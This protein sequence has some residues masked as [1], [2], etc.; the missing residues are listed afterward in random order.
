MSKNSIKPEP[1][2][3]G[4]FVNF[5]T[6]K[7]TT[8]IPVATAVEQP[9]MVDEIGKFLQA[10]L[11][12]T[13]QDIERQLTPR[14]A[15]SERTQMV[16]AKVLEAMTGVQA[17]EIDFWATN[18]LDEQNGEARRREIQCPSLLPVTS[19]PVPDEVLD[20]KRSPIDKILQKERAPAPY[21]FRIGEGMLAHLCEQQEYNLAIDILSQMI[22]N[23]RVAERTHFSRVR[24]ENGTNANYFNLAANSVN[25]HLNSEIGSHM[26][27]EQVIARSDTAN[28]DA[29]GIT[30]LLFGIQK[31]GK[32]RVKTKRFR[33][34][35]SSAIWKQVM[36]PM[37]NQIE[38]QALVQNQGIQIRR[39]QDDMPTPNSGPRDQPP[40]GHGL[41]AQ[42][43]DAIP[44]ST[45]FPP[46]LNVEQEIPGIPNISTKETT[47]DHMRR[48]MLK[49]FDLIPVGKDDEG[50]Y[51]PSFGPGIPHATD[52]R[53]TKQQGQTPS[54]D[55]I[56]AFYREHN[57]ELRVACARNEYDSED[58]SET[59]QPAKTTRRKFGN[60]FGR[61]RNRSLSPHNKRSRYDSPDRG[62]ESRERSGS[63]SYSKPREYQSPRVDTDR[64]YNGFETRKD[65]RGR[66]RGIYKRKGYNY[67]G[68]GQNYQEDRYREAQRYNHQTKQARRKQQ[69]QFG[70]NCFNSILH[71]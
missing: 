13:L 32:A 10:E 65:S 67:Q 66:G 25:S 27:G 7:F 62:G 39:I 1:S 18:I 30:N 59:T 28:K 43:N 33:Q 26:L 29:I 70:K 37:L 9:E 52:R 51:W 47:K 21:N 2:E 64:N 19:T 14:Q 55:D 56:K 17:N 57:F 38:N 58:D 36:R 48:W 4:L 15:V 34:L 16:M 8:K 31:L 5:D 41:Y 24:N 6:P 20:A 40:P 35:T 61:H 46:T 22:H 53:K 49:G 60:R 54:M 44:Q 68:R 3:P 23:L 12:P 50:H 63:R 42:R 45:I 69:E 71:S 11:Q